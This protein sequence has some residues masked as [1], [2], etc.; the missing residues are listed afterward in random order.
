MSILDLI[1]CDLS[2][3]CR[4]TEL[5][6]A[7]VVR[8]TDRVVGVSFSDVE[9]IDTHVHA[10]T[11][12]VDALLPDTNALCL[13]FVESGVLRV[14]NALKPIYRILVVL[15]F[16][17]ALFAQGSSEATFARRLHALFSLNLRSVEVASTLRLGTKKVDILVN[18]VSY[19]HG[20]EVG[21]V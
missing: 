1:R 17:T 18:V 14:N 4:R 11:K 8:I 12:L 6:A 5:F 2:Q 15:L 10:V 7:E 9:S 19:F 20:G 13:E 3:V 21:P 16:I